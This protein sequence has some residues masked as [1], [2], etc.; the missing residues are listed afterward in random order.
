M[1]NGAKFGISIAA[2]IAVGAIVAFLTAPLSGKDTRKVI[3][4]SVKTVSKKAKAAA[5]AIKEA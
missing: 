2:G 3:S 4:D 5:K 1:K